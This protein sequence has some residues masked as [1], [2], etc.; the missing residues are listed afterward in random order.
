VE[1]VIDAVDILTSER[2]LA[3]SANKITVSTSGLVPQIV[4]FCRRSPATLAVS[5]NATT[6]EVSPTKLPIH[7]V[8]SITQFTAH[9]PHGNRGHVGVKSVRLYAACFAS[10]EFYIVPY[11]MRSQ[12]GDPRRRFC[13]CHC[14]DK[15]PSS[16]AYQFPQWDHYALLLAGRSTR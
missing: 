13:L 15:Q 8:P 14:W 2:G 16:L 5:L 12:G 6:D 4:Q 7:F 9:R 11:C 10:A 3:L 1:A